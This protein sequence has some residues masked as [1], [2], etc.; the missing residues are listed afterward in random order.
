[1]PGA[2]IATR[3]LEIGIPGSRIAVP[4]PRLGIS[5][6]GFATPAA[7]LA[8]PGACNPERADGISSPPSGFFWRIPCIYLP[9]MGLTPIVLQFPGVSGLAESVAGEPAAWVDRV[10]VDA[11]AW[12]RGEIDPT[13]LDDRV[14]TVAESG[15][16]AVAVLAASGAAAETVA[17][18]LG[19]RCQRWSGERNPASEDPGF[20]HLLLCHRDLHPHD[21]PLLRADY[22]HALDVWQWVLRLDPEAG[23]AVQLAALFHDVERIFTEADSRGEQAVADYDDYKARHA[24]RSARVTDQVLREQ[25]AP[26]G[27]RTRVAELIAG[28]DQPG[29]VEGTDGELLEDAD[30]LSFFSLNSSGYLNYYGAEQ[31]R[32]KMGWTRARL[33]A[34]GRDW[35]G[36][37]RLPSG[38]AAL[39]T[40]ESL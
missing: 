38:V 26:S 27:L 16:F 13:E 4:G 23:A 9:A 33:S 17:E 1:M 6:P 7:R 12:T 39:M 35:L 20:A 10:E 40:G 37:L 28:H 5:G 22:R 19:I 2:G 24:E 30:A 11:A 15:P 29:R 34:R 36:R 3:A 25:G 14:D 18:D 31:A 8:I 21:K 32:R